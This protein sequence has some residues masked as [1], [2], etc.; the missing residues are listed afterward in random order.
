AITQINA[1]TSHTLYPSLSNPA[2]DE[3]DFNIPTSDPGYNAGTGA[4][5]IQPL[6]LL[7]TITNSVI[8]NDYS[9]P[10]ASPNTLANGDNAILRIDRDGSQAGISAVGLDVNAPTI[11]VQGFA[12]TDWGGYGIW[13]DYSSRNSTVAGN[14]L[15]TDV[16]GSIAEPNGAGPLVQNY[17]ANAAIFVNSGNN[18]IGGIDSASRNLISGNAGNGI[19][20]EG[21]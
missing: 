1:D 15:G 12:V 18:M 19:N 21:G 2:V 3:I 9:Q 4:F 6:S 17:A 5:T 11:R 14:F 20:I 10:G 16:T 8:I 7:P 13:L